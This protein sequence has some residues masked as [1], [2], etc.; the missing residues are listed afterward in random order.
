MPPPLLSA[1]LPLPHAWHCRAILARTTLIES[2]APRTQQLFLGVTR[3]PLQEGTYSVTI[4]FNPYRFKK[5]VSR[6]IFRMR[7]AIENTIWPLTPALAGGTCAAVAIRV[8]TAP[9]NSW[10]RSGGIAHVLWQW[11][12]MFPWEKNLPTNVRV[13]WLSL[14]AASCG[15]CGISF[16]QVRAI[17][18]ESFRKNPRIWHAPLP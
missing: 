12:E 5:H 16:V 14:V 18:S 13:A 9:S 4:T 1:P 8:L 2:R 6:V 10:W 11:D 17:L 7:K 3:R 15:L